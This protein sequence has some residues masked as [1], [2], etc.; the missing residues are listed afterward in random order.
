LHEAARDHG[1]TLESLALTDPLT[2]L[3]NRRLLVD[4]LSM[5][6]LQARRERAG[7][8][9]LYLD[10]DGFKSVNNTMGH[11]AGDALLKMVAGRLQSAVREQDTVARLGGDEFVI[12]LGRAGADEA[13][14]VAA[15]VIESVSQPYAIEGPPAR[16]TVSVGISLYPVHGDDPEALLKRAD[17]ALYEAKRSGKNVF[18]VAADDS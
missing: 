2:G 16:V 18:R 8:A 14:Q 6:L 13:A 3:A 1:K 4:R 7:M 11:A 5:G 12:V 15:K 17:L 10:L 9:L